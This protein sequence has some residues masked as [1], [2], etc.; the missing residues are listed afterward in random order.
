MLLHLPIITNT[1]Q[2]LLLL[3]N[4]SFTNKHPDGNPP[5]DWI[6][7]SVCFHKNKLFRK[8]QFPCNIPKLASVN[9]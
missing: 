3:V 9:C 8:L 7:L 4:V 2:N 5:Y 6:A 1:Q